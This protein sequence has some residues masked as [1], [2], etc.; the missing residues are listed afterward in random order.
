MRIVRLLDANN[1]FIQIPFSY[2]WIRLGRSLK[3]K[4]MVSI[5]F[6]SR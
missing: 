4:F 5:Q 6:H 2:L 1:S 3:L